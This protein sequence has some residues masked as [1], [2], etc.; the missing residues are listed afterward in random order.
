MKSHLFSTYEVLERDDFRKDFKASLALPA[1]VLPQIA[2]YAFQALAAPTR[3]EAD[4]VC[5]SAADTLGVA[6]SQLDHALSVARFFLEEFAPKGKAESDSPDTIA[7]D[8]RNAFSLT[9][10]QLDAVITMLAALRNLA[11]EK[12]ELVLLQKSYAESTLPILRTV[13]TSV[14]FRAMFDQSY[15]YEEDI[16]RF[17]PKFMGTV[18]LGIVE[19]RLS[20][21][22]CDEVFFQ[23]TRRTLQILL[24][25]LSALQLQMDIAET[26]LALK[27]R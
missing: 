13:S 2:D 1:H 23:V 14:D 5:K 8:L 27:D 9:A 18:P 7:E 21:A 22:H 12:V 15:K 10:E 25:H 11:R 6:K 26:G 20:G 24:D 16:T 4:K 19:L 17:K 3:A